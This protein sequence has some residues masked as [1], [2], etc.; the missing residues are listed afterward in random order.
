MLRACTRFT[1]LA[2]GSYTVTPSHTG[3]TFSPA[4]LAETISTANI[5]GA[6]FTS[7]A[8]PA[9]DVHDHRHRQ[10]NWRLGHDVDP[11]RRCEP[12]DHLERVG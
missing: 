2:K 11:K 12:D 5:T 10:R 9:A 7:T 1:G 3:F 4:S 8:T 6:N